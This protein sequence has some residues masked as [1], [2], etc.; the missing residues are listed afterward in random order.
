MKVEFPYLKELFFTTQ[1][2]FIGFM[3]AALAMQSSQLFGTAWTGF[4]AEAILYLALTSIQK[5]WKKGEK[6]NDSSER[7]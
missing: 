1:G 4:F 6:K 7:Q 2:I 5:E 3:L